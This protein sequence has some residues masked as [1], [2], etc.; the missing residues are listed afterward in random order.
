MIF[1]N[2]IS[3]EIRKTRDVILKSYDKIFFL[4]YEIM[5]DLKKYKAWLAKRGIKVVKRKSFS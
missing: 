3:D 2:S 5:E 4:L 1:G